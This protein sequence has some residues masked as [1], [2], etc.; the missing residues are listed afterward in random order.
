[1]P[2]LAR[3]TPDTTQLLENV[4][5]DVFDDGIDNSRLAEMLA[6]PDHL[7]F[8]ARDGGV[9]TGQCLGV[10]L[11]GPDRPPSLLIENLAVA[12]A[13]RR[14]GIGTALL[15]A[16]ID[17]GQALGAATMWLGVDP[18]SAPAQPFY[19]ALGLPLRTVAFTE[20]DLSDWSLPDQR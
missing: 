14:R 18:D 9:V 15:R 8:V 19:E 13:H 7:L 20:I 17:A 10:L 16:V 11:H 12:P 3:I 2:Q 1:M 6:R 5:D 4:A